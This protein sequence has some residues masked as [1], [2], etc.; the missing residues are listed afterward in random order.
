MRSHERTHDTLTTCF[1]S[2]CVVANDSVCSGFALKTSLN[3]LAAAG[4]ATAFAGVTAFLMHQ[5]GLTTARAL[6]AAPVC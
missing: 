4:P 3:R 2:K 6:R 1:F 5:A